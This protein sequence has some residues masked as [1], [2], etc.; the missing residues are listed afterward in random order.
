MKTFSLYVNLFF[1]LLCFRSSHNS[2]LQLRKSRANSEV[3]KNFLQI[4]TELS[5]RKQDNTILRGI[6]PIS[7]LKDKDKNKNDPQP[8][9]PV[10]PVAEVVAAERK[11]NKEVEIKKATIDVVSDES[12]ESLLEIEAKRLYEIERSNALIQMMF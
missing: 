11:E 8:V 6:F 2:N 12:Q 9:V 7:E 4:F 10:A 5:S 3:N 1:L